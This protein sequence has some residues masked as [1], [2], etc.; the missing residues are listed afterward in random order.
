MSIRHSF[1]AE[2]HGRSFVVFNDQDLSDDPIR[3][4]DIFECTCDSKHFA[5]MAWSSGC[6]WY[7]VIVPEGIL[8][9]NVYSSRG[10]LCKIKSR[11]F[12]KLYLDNPPPV[13]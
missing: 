11:Q 13:K 7:F 3:A 6:E 5:S 12:I 4:R 1:F 10:M 2:G 8:L 9:L